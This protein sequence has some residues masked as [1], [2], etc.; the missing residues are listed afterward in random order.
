MR[1]RM[2]LFANIRRDARVE[3]LSIRGLAKRY[4]IGRDTVRQALSDPVPPPRKTPERSSPRLDPFKLVIDA[5]LTEDTTAPRKQRHTARRILARLIE[6]QGAEELSYSTVRDYVRVRRAQIDVEAGR[7]VE[8]FIPQEHAPGAEAEV[9]F[10]EVWVILNGVKTKCHMFI[11][12]LSHSG[13]AVHRIYPTQAQEAF[14]EGHIE[15]FNVLGGVPTKHIRYDNLT[16]AVTAVVFGQGRQRQENDRWVLFRSHYGFDPFYCQPGIVGAHEKG[17]V[18]GEVGWFRRNRLSPMPVAESL[19]ELNDR[20][21]A[22]ETQDDGRRIEDRIRT[23]GRDFEAEQPFLAP[24]PAEVF[25]PG[26]VLNPRVDR[27]SMITVRM[28]KYSVPARFIGRKVRVSLRAS[29][30][31]VFDGSAV[32]ARHPRIVA[33]RGQSVQLDHYLEVLKTK[34]GALPGSTALARARE[35]GAFTSAHEAFWAASRRVNG[36]A[37]GTRELIDVLLLHRS[38]DAGDVEAGITA[39]LGVGAVNADVVAVEARRHATMSSVGGSGPDRHP[40]AHADVNVQRVVSL[41][42]R[43]LMDPAAVIAGLPPDTRSLPSIGAYDELLA[44]RTEHPAGTP[45]KE[46]TS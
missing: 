13:K 37:D 8:V 29:E 46:N 14:L 20:I 23:I 43:R 32:A 24:V 33:K 17:G 28:V 18:E 19:D 34:P 10:G 45:S 44:K 30:V 27:S 31:V 35:S 39:A 38:M 2:E 42:Q 16:S 3:G 25:D 40:G 26:L 21:R 1:V 6:E 22:W 7:R 36:D 15:A 12:R 5:M 4:Q 11:F 9:D 41:T